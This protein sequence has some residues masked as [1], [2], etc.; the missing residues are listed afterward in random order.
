MNSNNSADFYASNIKRLLARYPSFKTDILDKYSPSKELTVSET[1][2]GLSTA[3]IDNHWIQSSRHPVKEAQKLVQSG[4]SKK[5]GLCLVFG[6]GLGY[7]VEALMEQFPDLQLLI[8]EPEPELFLGAL[9]LR[10]FSALI[11]SENTGFLLNLTPASLS[12]ILS[13]FNTANFQSIKL[14]SVYER[15]LDYYQSVDEEFKTFIR[16]KETNMNT[17]NR[18]GRTWTRN[19][20]R[21]IE[22]FK[23]AGD[24]GLLYD[25][26]KEV[27]AIV[28]AAGPSLDEL[29][30]LLPEL[31]KR[32]LLICVDT[33][34]KAVL[35]S[36]TAPDFAV[37]VDPQY[38]NTR[39]LD[40]LLDSEMLSKT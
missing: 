14:R 33:A 16:K 7:H 19:L 38:L 37:V 8:I 22:V 34:L 15:N 2:E 12:S 13:Q 28:I 1:A 3:R 5:N 29:L 20:F 31:K 18:F 24:S 40:N 32:S 27:P 21:N 26:F 6:F 23:N 39:H 30:P 17:L 35:S 36:G 4:I 11:E 25:R 9:E 10:D